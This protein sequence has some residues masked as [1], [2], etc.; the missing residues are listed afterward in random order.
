MNE[1]I[2]QLEK[3]LD[4]LAC[5]EPMAGLRVVAALERITEQ[6]GRLVTFNVK[7]DD[8]SDEAIAKSLGMAEQ[9]VGTYLLRHYLRR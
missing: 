9:E 7:A 8:P 3:K 5:E 6:A 1:L 2:A 4:N